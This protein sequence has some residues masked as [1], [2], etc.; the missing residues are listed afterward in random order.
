MGKMT[1]VRPA[2]KGDYYDTIL[3]QLDE[4]GETDKVVVITQG[5]TSYD[6]FPAKNGILWQG[7]NIFFAGK[8][9]GFETAYQV[10]LKDVEN[11]EYDAYIYKY[12]FGF[13]NRCLRSF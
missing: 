8:S 12:R 4:A 5:S 1:E 11:L 6:M 10:M 3:V 2:Y 9:Y 13:E 7:S